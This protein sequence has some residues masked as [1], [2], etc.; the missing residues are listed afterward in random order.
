M[1]IFHRSLRFVSS[2]HLSILL[3][4]GAWL[5]LSAVAWPQSAFAQQQGQVHN[6]L[7]IPSS[8][9]AE[10]GELRTELAQLTHSGGKTADAAQ[11]LQEELRPHF[12]K[13]EKYALPPLG[14]L[15]P[16]SQG[17]ATSDMRAAIAL[18][19]ELKAQLPEMVIEHQA[20]EAAAQ[21]LESAGHE[22][23]KP[24]A[25]AFAKQLL[26][27]A[28]TEEQVLYPSAILVGEYLKLRLGSS[29]KQ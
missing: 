19:D 11:K 10:H 16:L 2:S 5:C 20:I 25:I 21:N 9:E 24:E 17:E 23:N 22:E 13:E 8:V 27:H 12:E 1:R 18:S 15:A 26:L 28:Q 3:A 6:W 7:R 29:A 4:F 14:L